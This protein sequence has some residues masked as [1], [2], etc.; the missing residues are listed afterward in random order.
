MVHS[1]QDRIVNEKKELNELNH[2]LDDL[3]ESLKLKK[4]QNDELQ[5]RL[6]KMREGIMYGEDEESKYKKAYDSELEK[7]KRDL[8]SVSEMSTLSKIRASRSMYDLD[9]VREMF[10]DEVRY[11]NATQEKIRMLE[12]QR[13][14]SL[15]ELSYLKENFESKNRSLLDDADRNAKLQQQLNSLSDQLDREQESRVDVECRIQTLL[16]QKKFD[17][18]LYATMRDELER[19]FLYKGANSIPDPKTFYINELRELKDKIREDFKKQS[20][21]NMETLREEY[22][23]KSTTQIEEIET[24]CFAVYY[25]LTFKCLFR[26]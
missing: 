13:A 8:N 10:D 12:N 9:R 20:E 16:E 24:V 21:F 7:A 26:N 14:E 4:A 11:Q 6:T 15:H 5:Q 19:M 3:V 22:E 18:E 25:I 1:Q 17:L 2:R 23:Y